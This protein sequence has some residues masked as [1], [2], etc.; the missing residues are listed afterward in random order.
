MNNEI[1]KFENVSFGY[2]DE[3][4]LLRNISFKILRGEFFF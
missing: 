4:D 2:G 1:V 3:S